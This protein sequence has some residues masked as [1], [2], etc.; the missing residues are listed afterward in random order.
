MTSPYDPRKFQLNKHLNSPDLGC[1]VDLYP[2]EGSRAQSINP[3]SFASNKK[4]TRE[5]TLDFNVRF[6]AVICSEANIL[7]RCSK[8]NKY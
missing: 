8:E 6:T 3:R 5:I 7:K 1:D 4:K 2:V